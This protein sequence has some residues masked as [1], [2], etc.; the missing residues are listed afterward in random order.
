MGGRG[1]S[2]ADLSSDLASVCQDIALTWSWPAGS[3]P[4]V[5]LQGIKFPQVSQIMSNT[6][7]HSFLYCEPSSAAAALVPPFLKTA[8]K[9]PHGKLLSALP[10]LPERGFLRLSLPL[11]EIFVLLVLQPLHSG[12]FCEGYH[13]G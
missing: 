4:T 1:G 2:G 3:T 8:F 12:D 6:L 7:R 5:R 9:E 11:R 13:F 10:L